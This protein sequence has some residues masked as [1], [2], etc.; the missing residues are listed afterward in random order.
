MVGLTTECERF[1]V[2]VQPDTSMA[3]LFASPKTYSAKGLL[4]PGCLDQHLAVVRVGPK[5][6]VQESE[7]A[8]LQAES[9]VAQ[10]CP[11]TLLRRQHGQLLVLCSR[12]SVPEIEKEI[13]GVVA[14][15]RALQ[16][17]RLRKQH[18]ACSCA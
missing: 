18:S 7:E 15:N 9:S 8:V 6:G 12:A 14:K 16:T 3:R 5:A 10:R 2:L 1:Q 4:A 11:N 13:Q 17:K